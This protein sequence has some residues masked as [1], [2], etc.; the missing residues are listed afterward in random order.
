MRVTGSD[1]DDRESQQM[2]GASLRVERRPDHIAVF[3]VSPAASASAHDADM[4]SVAMIGY[5]K[6]YEL[7]T[8]DTTAKYLQDLS[9]VNLKRLFSDSKP[10][11]ALLELDLELPKPQRKVKTRNWEEGDRW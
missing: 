5:Y 4:K 11:E 6:K 1:G 9:T 3:D 10:P 8:A 7:L 2:L